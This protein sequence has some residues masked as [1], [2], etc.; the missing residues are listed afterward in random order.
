AVEPAPEP[1]AE[2]P[3]EDA[4]GSAAPDV[5]PTTTVDL[6]VI[7][8][9]VSARCA[10]ALRAQ[11]ERL[12]AV[13]ADPLDTGFS[14][15]ATRAVLDHRA[16]V[17]GHD[18]ADLRAQ[19][20]EPEIK[21]AATEGRT[22]WVFTGQ[23]SQR[24]GMG[25]QLAATFPA[26]ATALDHVCSLLDAE[27]GF[28]Q[29]LRTVL[30]GDDEQV[31]QDTGYAQTALFALQVALI[32]LLRSWGSEPEVVLGHSVGEFAAAYAAGVLELPD[33][34]RLV[35]ARA[36][37]MRV[38][39]EGGAMAAIEGTEK[40][41]TA[42]LADGAVVAAV[43]S[44]TSVVVSGRGD[45]VRHLV[46]TARQQGRRATLLSVSHAFHSPLMEPMLAEFADIAAQAT[47]HRPTLHAVSTLTG[48]VLCADDWTTA[49]YW[50]R[51]V[52]EA[53][54]FHDAART[55]VADLGVA[56][57]LEIGPDP[58]LSALVDTVPAVCVLRRDRDERETT[59]AAVAEL[60]VR[61]THVDWA[62]VFAGTGAREVPLP[63]YAFQRRRSWLEAPRTTVDAAGLGLRPVRHPLLGAAVSVADTDTM[64][65]TAR[66]SIADQPW[67]A[68]HAVAGTV[69]VPGTALL[70]LALAAG[71]RAGCNHIVELT[72]HAPLALP[73]DGAVELQVS[74]EPPDAAGHRALRVHAR[75]HDTA[76]ELPWTLHASGTSAAAGAPSQEEWDLRTW[77]P[78]GAEQV[79]LDGL[80]ERL[81]SVGLSY[82]PA[83]RGLEAVWRAGD[84]WFV[85]ATLPDATSGDGEGFGVHPALLDTV[86]HVL[87]LWERDG[88]DAMLPF[89]W[90]G[91]ELSAVGASTVRVRVRRRGEDA[92]EL[93]VAD[94][95]GEPVATID[96]LLLRAVTLTDLGSSGS[97]V[98]DALFRVEWRPMTTAGDARNSDWGVL[99]EVPDVQAAR[100]T[101]P[102]ADLEALRTALDAGT[103]PPSTVLLPIATDARSVRETVI[104]AL[105]S[106]REWLQEPRLA[107]TRLM[108]VLSGAAEHEEPV[109]EPAAA[110]VRGLV[111]TAAAEHPGRFALADLDLDSASWETLAGVPETMSEVLIRNGT[112]RVPRL[113]RMAGGDVLVPPVGVGAG[114]RMDVVAQGRLDGV[115]LV[116][117]E[118]RPLHAGEVRVAVRAAGMNFRDVL[119]VLGMYPGDA[120][121]LGHE[122][123]GV[124]V[125]VGPDVTG[126]A[127]GDRVMGLLDAAFAPT[128]VTDARLLARVPDGWSFEQA[129]SV[130]LV[131]LTAYYA[132][133]DLAGLGAGESLLVHSAAGG[134]GMAAVQLARHLGGEVY[135]TASEPKWPAVRDLGVPEERIASSRTTEF[136]ERFQPGV[137]VVLGSLAG[138]FVDASLRL[139]RPGG[140][141][142]EM[143]KTDIREPEQV[144]AHHGIDYTSFDHMDAG[145]DRIAEM[146]AALL[147]LFERGVLRPNPVTA[148]EMGRAPE[149]LRLLGQAGHVG[150]VVLRVPSPWDGDGTVLITGGTG[151]LGAEVARHL[152]TVHGVRDLLLVSRRGCEAP[153][154]AELRAE[155][156]GLGARVS[157]RACDV[158]DREALA[159]L[160]DG[161]DLSGVVHAAGVLDDGLIAD[162]TAERLA[163]VL[164]AKAESALHLHELTADRKLSAFVLFSSFAGVVGNPGQGA[165]SAANNVLDALAVARRAQ[166]LPAVSL[167]WG[168][169]AT[170]DGMGG[171]LGDAEQERMAR[172]GFPALETGEGL[173]LLDAALAANEPTVVPVALR[174]SAL[175]EAGH[176]ALP[177]VLH[178]LVP[179]RARRRTV[180]AAS[181][182]GGELARRLAELAPAEQRRDLLELVRAQVAKALG[183]ASAASVD[184]TR[185]FKDLGFDSL[186]AVD[187]RNRLGS[188][189][190][191]ALP[192][193]LVFDHPN[194]KSLTDHLLERVVGE[195]T[196]PAPS[197]PRTQPAAG[198]DEAV[199]IV[200]MGCRFPGGV[201]SPGALWDL[202][203]SGGDGVSGFP[204][205]RG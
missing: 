124:V 92:V 91:V 204:V 96:S 199:A 13:D 97:F 132:L 155:L 180:D 131:F 147:E 139:V 159:V 151:G 37:L 185:S 203:A 119:N 149:A 51:Q 34:V 99:G 192:A 75:P 23:G 148:F 80:Y 61:G 105:G 58:V 104:E 111:R 77:P 154:A 43:N 46:E 78:Q 57:F 123:A 171:T 88:A 64:L 187:L 193:T 89:L 146:W 56:R 112:A 54:R 16:V 38:L 114:W 28:G 143:G 181:A 158:A 118:P 184:E 25:R 179:V 166:G 201:D 81:G 24:P 200:G 136:E 8:W 12:T 66:L 74:V 2:P 164:A 63:T 130:P 145:R 106:I 126:L 50:V 62:A 90:S 142:V 30:F 32:R 9:V 157:V 85:Q 27:L 68:D 190:G 84:D 73:T 170:A 82:G 125:E 175:G 76:D 41:V 53:V 150:K 177:A 198:V 87:G 5:G 182:D 167:A 165:Y 17:L 35:A 195:V 93:R 39:P 160:I 29:P 20:G 196:A 1:A 110:A 183:H 42:L 113:V 7:P 168:M 55:A 11:I 188:A 79:E 140:R 197:Q 127:V 156:E 94:A 52:R 162:L 72:L 71:E 189:T 67:L 40:E 103:Q 10:D 6:P 21:G 22:A 3:A 69:I 174:T 45:A 14:L 26:F 108:I 191:I 98:R 202:V 109:N 163:G 117:E 83:F 70:E 31:L 18:L 161:V 152:V 33:A 60:F 194:P 15:A 178:D 173:A 48:A 205:D 137:D 86:L 128:A 144:R 4:D 65:L 36:R 120:G 107:E 59:L 134:V 129:A 49:D 153:G 135:A 172:Q 176:G 141:F 186:T 133:V 44:A 169:W 101:T 122:G 47:Y 102:Y 19:L 138:E 115:R 121:R 116:P 100:H 95:T